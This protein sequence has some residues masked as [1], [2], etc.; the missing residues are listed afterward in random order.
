M[1]RRGWGK[2]GWKGLPAVERGL[3]GVA[4]LAKGAVLGWGVI[5]AALGSGH[6][7]HRAGDLLA[8]WNRWDAPHYLFVAQHGYAPTG[9][10]R[11][12]L[13]FFPLY[14]WLVRATAWVVQDALSAAFLV[15]GVASV[16]AVVLLYRLARLDVAEPVARRAALF[17][18]VFPT[19]YFL[20]IPYTESLFLALVLLAF[21]AA[22]EGRW[23]VAGLVGVLAS[24]TRPNGILLLPALAVEA[25]CQHRQQSLRGGWW[26]LGAVPG[27]VGVHLLVNQVVAGHPTAFLE[28]LRTHWHKT[29]NWP[30]VGLAGTYRSVFWRTPYEAHMVGVQELLYAA[31]GALVVGAAVRSLPASY[32]VWTA[33]NW[34]ASVSTTFVLSVPR[35]TLVLFPV[36]LLMARWAETPRRRLALLGWCGLWLAYFSCQFAQGRWAF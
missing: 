26:W 28:I 19:S 3:V 16:L 8:V 34:L 2:T 1:S 5:C 12:F 20:H 27:G 10:G 15:S 36:Y 7:V 6:P 22:R 21:L 29:L 31:L 4:L 18:L 14:P 17:A 23:R 9:E 25:W 33:T 13:V 32:A 30:W 11:L 24:L 35:Y